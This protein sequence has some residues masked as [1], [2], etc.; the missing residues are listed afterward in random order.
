MWLTLS[1]LGKYI[2]FNPP[3]DKRRKGKRGEE[4]ERE[5]VVISY[6]SRPRLVKPLDTKPRECQPFEYRFPSRSPM[7]LLDFLPLL[8][9]LPYGYRCFLHA[10]KADRANAPSSIRG[11]RS[12]ETITQDSTQDR[13]LKGTRE[14][15]DERGWW[16]KNKR[17]IIRNSWRGVPL[18]K[19]YFIFVEWRSTC[20]SRDRNKRL[21][22]I[23][24]Y[25]YLFSSIE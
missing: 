1:L 3:R 16:N 10:G 14:G 7:D 5:I 4:R 18:E 15:D 11:N 12:K 13:W 8:S 2:F 20:F 21:T 17:I 22:L 24:R 19:N 9:T 25:N 23:S 6:A